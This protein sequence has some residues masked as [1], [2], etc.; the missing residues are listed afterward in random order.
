MNLFFNTSVRTPIPTGDAH[1]LDPKAPVEPKTGAPGIAANPAAVSGASPA[2]T[3]PL[4]M[5]SPAFGLATAPGNALCSRVSEPSLFP[6]KNG[7]L[8]SADVVW[9]R[10]NR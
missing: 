2:V 6:D 3:K 1:A 8:Y 5:T 7:L 9:N 10:R 4:A